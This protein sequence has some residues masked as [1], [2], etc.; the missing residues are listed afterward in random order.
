MYKLNIK[1][2]FFPCF[3]RIKF[4]V[5]HGGEQTNKKRKKMNHFHGVAIYELRGWGGER[6]WRGGWRRKVGG[7]F[8]MRVCASWGS[9]RR[10]EKKMGWRP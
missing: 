2:R 3:P 9:R 8:R 4:C 5:E 7:G 10:G 1:Y 6:K